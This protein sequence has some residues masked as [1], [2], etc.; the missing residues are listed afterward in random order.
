[1]KSYGKDGYKPKIVILDEL[2]TLL[3]GEQ[4]T[5]EKMFEAL[6][7]LDSAY[8]SYECSE[9]CVIIGTKEFSDWVAENYD[10]EDD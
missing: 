7:A 4:G 5:I 10:P 2:H 1:M 3:R 8:V 6:D 9:H